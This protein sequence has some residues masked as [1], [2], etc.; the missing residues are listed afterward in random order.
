[1]REQPD[2]QQRAKNQSE[3][4]GSL[5]QRRDL[6]EYGSTG[7]FKIFAMRTETAQARR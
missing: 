2:D 1:M 3:P 5:D 6:A 4:A 7:N